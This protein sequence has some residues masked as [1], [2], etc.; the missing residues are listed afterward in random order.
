MTD[1]KTTTLYGL[2][3]GIKAEVRERAKELLEDAYPEDTLTEMVDSWVPIYNSDLLD[4][5]ADN[6]DMALLEPEVGPAFDGTPTPI[7]IIAANIYEAL[8][9][10]AFDEWLKVQDEAT[11]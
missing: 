8:N 6:M 4:V 5:A 3:Q 1:D 7:N 11:T 2:E 10:A 9:V